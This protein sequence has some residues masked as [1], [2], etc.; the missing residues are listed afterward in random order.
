MADI[1]A[2]DLTE[3]TAQTL[4]GS[5]QFVM[6]DNVEGKRGGIDVVGDYI[7]QHCDAD[8]NG[9]T[10]AQLVEGAQADVNKLGLSVVNGKLNITY[11]V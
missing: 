6:F 9:N 1:N 2:E 7:V 3:E 8:G 5:E 11:T 10:A 4:D